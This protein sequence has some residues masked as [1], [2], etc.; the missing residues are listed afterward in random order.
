MRRQKD[1]N[2]Q[3]RLRQF[4]ERLPP[5][6]RGII[7]CAFL[8][9]ALLVVTVEGVTAVAVI[10]GAIRTWQHRSLGAAA[11]TRAGIG[12]VLCGALPAG[13]IRWMVVCGHWCA[14][15]TRAVL[16]S[17][18]SVASGGWSPAQPIGL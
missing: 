5:V 12:P 1:R 18:L 2:R 9:N 14:P 7:I 10:R 3:A 6:Q 4:Y 11:A 15:W 17:G 13:A 16:L 8:G